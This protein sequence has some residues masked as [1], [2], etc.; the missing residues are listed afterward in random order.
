VVKRLVISDGKG[1]EE[2]ILKQKSRAPQK[3]R[4]R[5]RIASQRLDGLF[6]GGA[7]SLRLRGQ[8][9]RESG[10]R[11]AARK[12]EGQSLPELGCIE[13]KRRTGTQQVR[14]WHAPRFEQTVT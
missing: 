7:R 8:N 1:S 14:R 5:S 3:E 10:A 2:A 6:V 12:S 4:S 13:P 9:L 11:S